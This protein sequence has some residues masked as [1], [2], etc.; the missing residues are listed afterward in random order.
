MHDG[1]TDPYSFYMDSIRIRIHHLRLNTDPD[2]DPIQILGFDDKILKK[3]RGE[4]KIKFVFDQK[5][6]FTYP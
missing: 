5:L 2:P 4:K 1:V 3:F 6:H